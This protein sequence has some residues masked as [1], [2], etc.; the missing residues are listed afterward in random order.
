[1]IIRKS[2]VVNGFIP[3][4]MFY[5]DFYDFFLCDGA[6]VWIALMCNSGV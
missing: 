4:R 5:S 3:L 6:L 2:V 1:M